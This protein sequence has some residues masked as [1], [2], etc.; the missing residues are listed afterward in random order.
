MKMSWGPRD[1]ARRKGRKWAGEEETHQKW[2]VGEGVGSHEGLKDRDV[3]VGQYPAPL[4]A[5]FVKPFWM[6]GMNS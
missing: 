3:S 4:W 6:V 5:N 1:R 2:G